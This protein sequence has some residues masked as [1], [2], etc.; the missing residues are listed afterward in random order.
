MKIPEEWRMFG[1][2]GRFYIVDVEDRPIMI[3]TY[4]YYCWFDYDVDQGETESNEY[5]EDVTYIEYIASVTISNGATYGE[6][7][8]EHE[9]ERTPRYYL[10]LGYEKVV[11]LVIWD[12]T[13]DEEMLADIADTFVLEEHI[14]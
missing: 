14:K 4:S 11:Y 13:M 3:Q 2:D 1:K 6:V 12:E 8:V 10:H 5:Y 7:L 9:N